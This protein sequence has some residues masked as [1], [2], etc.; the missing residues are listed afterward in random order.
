MKRVIH[1]QS[2]L[3]DLGKFCDAPPWNSIVLE[4]DRMVSGK[5]ARRQRIKE[6]HAVIIGTKVFVEEPS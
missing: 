4:K 3:L 1:T 2:K 5:A 6:R